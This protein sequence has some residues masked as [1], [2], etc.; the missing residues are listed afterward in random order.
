MK[1]VIRFDKK[2]EKEFKM[3]GSIAQAKIKAII[4]ILARDGK[5]IEPF[6]KKIDKDLF[7][8]RVESGGQYRLL[9]AYLIGEYIII[10][11]AFQK[12]TQQTPLKEI[13][14]A[15]ARLNSYKII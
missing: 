5:L 9:Y 8:I 11:S 10:L 3:F 2:A 6:G 13:K 12:K 4:D 15:K 1:K 7:E 14:K